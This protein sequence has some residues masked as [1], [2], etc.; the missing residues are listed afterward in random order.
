M[1]QLKKR[2]ELRVEDTWN[3]ADMYETLEAWE[4]DYKRAEELLEELAL[5]KGSLRS[6]LKSTLDLYYETLRLVDKI[7]VYAHQYSDQDTA[8]SVG[9]SIARKAQTLSIE[10]GAKTSYLIPEILG[11]GETWLENKIKSEPELGYYKRIIKEMLRQNEHVRS[12]EIEEILAD[13]ADLSNAP[14][15][16]YTL[17]SNA[18]LRFGEISDENGNLVEIT[19]GNLVLFLENKNRKTRAA[20]FHTFYKG[21]EQF[22]NTFAASYYANVRQAIF[23][24]K[25]RHY[26]S[27]RAMYLD[28][29]N[30][31]EAVYDNLIET[32]HKHLDTMYRYVK[33]RK[34]ILEVESLHMY[35]VYVPIVSEEQQ[36]YTIEEAK[37]LVLDGL[38]VMGEEYTSIL[39]Q[40]FEN[41]WIDVY[42]NE[43]KKSGAYSWG[44]YDS[45]PYVL[46]NFQGTLNDVFTLAHEMGHSLHNYYSKEN[47]GFAYADYR[48]FVAEVASTC[49]E[50]LLIRYLLQETKDSEQKAYLLN[51]FLDKFK[52]TMF[53]QTMFAEFEKETH[54][55]AEKKTPLTAELLCQIY[56]E[57]NERYFGPDMIID[58]EISMEWARIPH[59]YRPFYVY[60]YA[61]GFAAAVALSSRILKEG[62]QALE[63]YK[64]FLKGGSSMDSIDLLKLAGVDMT[65]PE[66]IEEA[67]NVFA[68][69]LD[70]LERIVIS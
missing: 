33:L 70:E 19:S 23:F 1:E 15:D 36:S 48:I 61:T 4:L 2:S 55:L 24:S 59:F 29:A 21:L 26:H 53:R 31:P 5:K 18:D 28:D 11:L 6:T 51:Y 63:D 3:L 27:T 66:P 30:I 43:G 16:I 60:Q 42:P 17:L 32:T 10:M 68:E 56:K 40:G 8:N 52:G 38:H 58:P 20:A 45:N 49:N 62:E 7:Y 44:C 12:A 14:K 25:A 22:K 50:A 57:L 47:Q 54:K 65:K 13:A 46:L 41:R 64:K 9:Q 34:R 37:Q 69:L 39:K 67:L 35:D